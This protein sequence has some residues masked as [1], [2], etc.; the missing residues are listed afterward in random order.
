MLDVA[1]AALSTAGLIADA[2]HEGHPP[3]AAVIVLSAAASAPLVIRRRA[4][5]AGLV[6]VWVGLTACVLLVHPY[7]AATAVA[8]VPL[9]GVAVSSGRRRSLVAGVLGAVVL[10]ALSSIIEGSLLT[11]T[12][13]VRACSVSERSWSGISSARG[14]SCPRPNVSGRGASTTNASSGPGAGRPPN[15]C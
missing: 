3:L 15:A 4:P 6:L 13:A 5:I 14:G 12:A 10:A 11:A 2:L 1:L 9:Y 7:N 8:M